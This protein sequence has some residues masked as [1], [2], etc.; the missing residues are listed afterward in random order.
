MEHFLRD[1]PL[2][3]EVAR[4]KSFTLAAE[5]LEMPISTLSRRISTLEKNLGL[6]LL[7]RNSRNVELTDSGKSFYKRCA[8]IVADA[9]EACDAITQNISKPSGWVRFSIPGDVYMSFF[10]ESLATFAKT[11]PEI[12][13]DIRFTESRDDLLPE[14]YDLGL[15]VGELADSNLKAR[16]LGS[17]EPWI[18]A[19]PS[20]MEEYATPT[21]PDDLTN[22]PCIT[23]HGF[24]I[25]EMTN[26]AGEMISVSLTPV[27]T[28]N[29]ISA[30]QSFIVAGLG[31][32]ALPGT[33]AEQCIN[34]GLLVRILPD[35]KL[36]S[37]NAYLVMPTTPVP[38]RVRLLI[39]Y[40][41]QDNPRFA[42]H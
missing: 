21:H 33:L 2:F 7:R 13:L 28:F 34:Q 9:K 40:L 41:V 39:D 24:K 20:L 35:W 12:H 8:F 19:A 32:G 31:I 10:E 36:P 42:R 1:M 22:I 14:P 27:H 26:K 5:V 29:N 18:C 6:P 3:V 37:I 11:W 17:G 30:T 15:R 38:L 25:W 23:A 16:R 4:N